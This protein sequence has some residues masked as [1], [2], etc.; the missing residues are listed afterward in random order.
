MEHSHFTIPFERWAIDV[1]RESDVLG[2]TRLLRISWD[3]AWGIMER[4]VARGR[5]TKRR[6]VIPHLGVDEKAIAKG[7]RYVTLVNDLDRG[8]VEY[9]S[10]DRK[11]ESLEQYNRSL[12]A[13]Q[14]A[15]IEAIAMDMWDPYIAATKAHVPQAEQK[16]VFDRY[17]LMKY[18]NEAVDEVRKEE[19]R[20]CWP[21]AT[22]SWWAPNTCGCMRKRTCPR[23]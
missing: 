1:L 3:E 5:H 6:R 8:T 11:Q 20:R 15:G 14:L 21:R 23:A 16:I 22:V 2:A 10:F 7:H 9:V 17:H 4:T 12:S 19:H 13:R 18:M